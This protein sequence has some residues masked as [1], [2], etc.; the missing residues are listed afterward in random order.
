M[1]ENFITVA[2][3][4]VDY[5]NSKQKSK[6]EFQLLA[7][8]FRNDPH[9]IHQGIFVVTPSGQWLVTAN[10]GW[11]DPDPDAALA[12]MK[13]ALAKYN[14]MPKSERLLAQPL[15][16]ADRMTWEEDQ[17]I[18][19]ERTLDL[20]VVKRGYAY[21]GMETFDE[22]HP[23]F[24]GIDRL[25]FKPSEFRAYVPR[26]YKVGNA[27]KVSGP[28]M[29]RYILM[30]HMMKAQGAW[31]VNHIKT[32]DMTSR[33]TKIEGSKIHLEIR[34]HFIASA[35]TQ[36][37]KASYEGNLL[38]RA[39]YDS[40]SDTMTQ[41][42]AVMLGTHDVGVLVSNLHKGDRVQRVASSFSLNPLSDADDRMLP[43][44]W[45]WGYGLRWCRTP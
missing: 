21:P 17:F 15:T 39:V 1:K 43:Q 23:K 36:W 8:V 44:Q 11:P 16:D 4:D 25:W 30:S 26:E 33:I 27:I 24:F 35:N 12:R 10:T 3:D 34:A 2:A 13:Q 45:F 20:R 29:E 22:R 32:G 18:K 19:P 14:A 6:R 42:E 28:A 40:A 31:D 41:F 9:G 7:N 37:N 5:N 38:G